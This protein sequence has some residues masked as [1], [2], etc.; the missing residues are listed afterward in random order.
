MIRRLKEGAIKSHS[1][2]IKPLLS[3]KNRGDHVEWW[4]SHIA[5]GIQPTNFDD[6][7]NVVHIDEKWFYLTKVKRM[8]YLAPDEEPLV[9]PCQSKRFI[10]KVMFMAGVARPRFD[11]YNNQWFDG[12]I[13]A[14]PFVFTEPAKHNSKNRIAGTMVT[15][16]IESINK[17]D[18]RKMLIDI[19]L[20]AIREKWPCSWARKTC[21]KILIQ[22]DNAELH[23]FENYPILEAA[24]TQDGFDIQL[25]F[26]PSNSPNLNILD[27]GFFNV[28][29][30]L[31]H[32]LVQRTFDDMITA[33]KH[34][35]DETDCDTIDNVFLSLQSVMLEA[36]R[37]DGANSYKLP[38]LAKATNRC[39]N[40][41]PVALSVNSELIERAKLFISC[42]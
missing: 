12:K 11:T 16:C 2:V 20:P 22:Q 35:Y 25:T 9:R 6:M 38:H 29:Q 13:G 14:F 37:V 30:S 32:Q 27:L 8:F 42:E 31:Q 34:A 24:L 10:P 39:Q 19:I 5:L 40:D 36:M 23:G 3:D 15:K 33:T 41:L 21:S 1:N 26:Q 7:M 17:E 18:T 28:I 4:L